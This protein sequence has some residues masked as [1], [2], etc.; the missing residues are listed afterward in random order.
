MI[1]IRHT[2]G[3]TGFVGGE[4]LQTEPVRQVRLES[5]QAPL[6]QTLRRQQQVDMQ[7]SAQTAD[8]H[9]QLR[10]IRMLAQQF[11]KLVD[12]DEECR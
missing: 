12:D 6:V 9:E 4:G 11:G 1:S 10:E 7:R 8:R 2:D 3:R 5:T